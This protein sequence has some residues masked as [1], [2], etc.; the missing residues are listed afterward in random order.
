[1]LVLIED[2]QL[3]VLGRILL[4]GPVEVEDRDGFARLGIAIASRGHPVADVVGKEFQPLM[5]PALVKQP[6]FAIEELLHLTDGRFTHGSPLPVI[7]RATF[8]LSSYPS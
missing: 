6:G 1:V 2:G 7:P 4:D 5:K 8:Q 3:G